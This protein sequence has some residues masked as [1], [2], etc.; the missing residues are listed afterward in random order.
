MAKHRTANSNGCENVKL[1]IFICQHDN[2]IFNNKDSKYKTSFNREFSIIKIKESIIDDYFKFNLFLNNITI[3]DFKEIKKKFEN[4]QLVYNRILVDI[5]TGY[6]DGNQ[7]E[8]L[9]KIH[10]YISKENS[11]L[12]YQLLMLN[13]QPQLFHQL[14]IKH[15]WPTNYSSTTTGSPTTRAASSTTG[16]PTTHAVSSTQ[17][18]HAASSTTTGPSTTHAASSTTT[19]PP[20]THA[21]PSIS[22]GPHAAPST[23]TGPPTTHAAP[24]N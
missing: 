1:K 12:S 21:A 7:D 18:F 8:I 17:L 19:G 13:H 10:E 16:S 9:F 23:T 5:K 4:N 15:Y 24:L 3:N 14:L 6:Y 22:T 2:L 20:T 11:Q